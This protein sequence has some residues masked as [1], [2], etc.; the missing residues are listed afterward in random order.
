MQ[1]LYDAAGLTRYIWNLEVPAGKKLVIHLS[2]GLSGDKGVHWENYTCEVTGPLARS[3]NN[4]FCL[5]VHK[6]NNDLTERLCFEIYTE[7]GHPSEGRGGGG[8]FSPID[9]EPGLEG[10][11]GNWGGNGFPG[12]AWELRLGPKDAPFRLYYKLDAYLAPADPG[13]KPGQIVY[14]PN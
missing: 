1:D 11:W 12:T 13:A 14:P 7:A 3:F 9:L 10:S 8:S 5:I 4:R 2:G 6:T